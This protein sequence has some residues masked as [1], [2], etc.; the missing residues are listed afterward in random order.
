[1]SALCPSSVGDVHDTQAAGS[2]E[3]KCHQKL[4]QREQH[5]HGMAVPAEARAPLV[6]R[7]FEMAGNGQLRTADEHCTLLGRS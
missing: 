4:Q 7:V 5:A 2:L 6:V 1:V 3:A